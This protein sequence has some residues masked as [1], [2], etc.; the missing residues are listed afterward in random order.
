MEL[1][2]YGKINLALDV[3]RR[4]EDGYHDITS[5]MQDIGI[6][7]IVNVTAVPDG[8]AAQAAEGPQQKN[9]EN[10]PAVS[11][12]NSQESSCVIDDIHVDFCI[13]NRTIPAGR[14]NLAVR[15]AEAV[16]RAAGRPEDRR[17]IT[18]PSRIS[19]DIRKNLPIAAGLAGGSAD[20][21]AAMLGVNAILGSPFSMRE[22]MDMGARIGADV[23][24]SLMMNTSRNREALRD[25]RGSDEASPAARIAGIGDIVEPAEPIH[26]Y[27]ILFNPGISVSTGEVYEAVDR[28]PDKGDSKGKLFYNIMEEYTLHTYREAAE[29]SEAMRRNLGAD[30]ILMSGSGPTMVAYYRDEEKARRD[31]EMALGAGWRREQWKIWFTESGGIDDGFRCTGSEAAE[32]TGLPGT[33]TQDTHR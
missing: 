14:K 10:G 19:I 29:L 31:H 9:A 8:G 24:F 26:R 33:E 23:P 11:L 3:L 12:K 22:L 2:A 27:V 15:G 21:A 28:M 1:R 25:L 32:R 13:D 16:I 6:C 30:D 7:D 18:K 17:S 5:F 4:R 20:A